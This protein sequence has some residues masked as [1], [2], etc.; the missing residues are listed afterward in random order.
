MS[1]T[2]GKTFGAAIFGTVPARS[3]VHQVQLAEELCFDSAWVVDSQLLCR[4]AY[5][6]L[7]ACA[8]QTSRIKLATGVTNPLTRHPSV[9]ASAAITLDELSNGRM[10]VGISTGN[11]AVRPV[12]L[13]PAT[14]AEVEQYVSVLTHLLRNQPAQ[15]TAGVQGKINWLEKPTAIPVYVAATNPKLTHAAGRFADGAILFQGI[16]PEL[17]LRGVQHVT[18]GAAEALRQPNAVDVALWVPLSVSSDGRRARDNIRG[19]VAAVLKYSRLDSFAGPDREV[20]QRLKQE[21]DYFEHTSAKARHAELVSDEMIDR[22]ALAGTPQEVREKLEQLM[23]LPG[24]GKIIVQP[25]VSDGELS[26]ETVFRTFVD[27]VLSH[28]V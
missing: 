12:G 7:A 14:V 15:F 11:S 4:E 22:Y 2:F 5:V 18:A 23:R 24:F 9:V 1:K 25:E 28:I 3:V 26:P 17:V 10:M 27:D 20:V 13:K 6:T 16:S 8:V 19:R 21:Y